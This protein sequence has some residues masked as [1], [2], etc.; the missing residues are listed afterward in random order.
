MVEVV[1]Q[2][3]CGRLVVVVGEVGAKGQLVGV[4]VGLVVCQH[5]L[6]CLVCQAVV[7]V[8]GVAVELVVEWVSSVWGQ[9]LVV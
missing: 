1:E 3:L 9:W 4:G 2:V 8:L 5:M 7:V 6:V